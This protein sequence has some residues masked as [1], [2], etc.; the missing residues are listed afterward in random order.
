MAER[1]SS[2]HPSV[3]TVRTT[4][5]ETATGVELSIPA[6][7]RGAFPTDEVV[8]IVLDGDERFARVKRALTGDELSIPA[9]YETPDLARDP[10]GGV[11]R[12]AEWVDD[13]GI[14][15]GGSVLVDVVEPDFLYGL[16]EPGDMAYYD[17]YEPPEESLSDIAENLED[18]T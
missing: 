8:R 17:A 12:L 11:D 15:T 3:R 2:D 6:D 18:G 13:H 16:R 1:V 14:V 5:T 9:V 7:D 10:S 4:C